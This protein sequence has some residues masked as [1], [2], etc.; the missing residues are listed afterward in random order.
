MITVKRKIAY[1][2]HPLMGKDG[3]KKENYN[4]N[5]VNIHKICQYMIDK[6]RSEEIIVKTAGYNISALTKAGRIGKEGYTPFPFAPQIYFPQFNNEAL[7]Q[8]EEDFELFRNVAIEFCMTILSKLDEVHVY[9]YHELSSGV[10][11]DIERASGLGIPVFFKEYPWE[12][13]S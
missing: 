5:L 3:D 10:I 12:V 11:D 7:V 4:N 8:K 2:A 9:K 13:N 6:I 1:I